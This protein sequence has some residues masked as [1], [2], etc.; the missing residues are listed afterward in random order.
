MP[1]YAFQTLLV[2]PADHDS[3]IPPTPYILQKMKNYTFRKWQKN[4]WMNEW[5]FSLYFKNRYLNLVIYLTFEAFK[6]VEILIM[7]FLLCSLSDDYQHF[8]G[9]RQW[10]HVVPLAVTNVLERWRWKRAVSPEMLVTMSLC[11]F[12]TKNNAF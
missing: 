3:F 8:R 6:A 10:H 11:F 1:F 4:E 7:V 5:Q 12:T 2:E 9:P